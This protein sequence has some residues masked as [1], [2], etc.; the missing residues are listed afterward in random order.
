M[1]QPGLSLSDTLS[2]THVDAIAA[3]WV[4]DDSD[5]SKGATVMLLDEDP[6]FCAHVERMLWARGL[7]VQAFN[8]VEDFF[9]RAP[10]AKAA[11]L[12]LEAQLQI[13]NG[14]DIQRHLALAGDL[15]PLVFATSL[16]CAATAVQA[17]KGGAIDYLVKPLRD[18]ALLDAV[19]EAIEHGG[20]LRRGEIRVFDEPAGG[21]AEDS[22]ET[23]AGLNAL[24]PREREVMELIAVGKLNKQVAYELGISEMTVKVHRGRVMKKMGARTVVDLVRRFDRSVK[25]TRS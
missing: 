11:C 22:A 4:H 21:E 6:W 23:S 19:F 5:G 18:E 12:I 7:N 10:C 16:D 2:N 8:R 1:K 24:T 20:A 9:S 3:S 25:G 15:T 14:L 17:M 13:V